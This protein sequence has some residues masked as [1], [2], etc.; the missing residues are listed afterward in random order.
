MPAIAKFDT[1]QTPAGVN[2]GN[3]IQ[4]KQNH[5]FD[6]SSQAFT[7][8]TIA[9]MTDFNISITPESPYSKIMIFVRWSG[10]FSNASASTNSMFGLR[11]NGN[12]IGYNVNRNASAP[13]GIAIP[14]ISIYAS[15]ADS[16]LESCDFT[17]IDSP[18]KTD[19]IVYQVTHYNYYTS[20]VYTNRTVSNT[21]TGEYELPTSSITVMEIS[22]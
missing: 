13:F 11:R 14:K 17:Y 5:F 20:T 6:L 16:T 15:D 3:I 18:S 8:G 9:D 1:W 21:A 19:T 12:D 10:E 4:V 22:G 2:R 7:G